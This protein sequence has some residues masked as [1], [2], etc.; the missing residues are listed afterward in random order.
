MT[1]SANT[2]VAGDFVFN[3]FMTLSVKTV[4]ACHVTLSVNSVEASVTYISKLVH[5]AL[6]PGCYVQ[7]YS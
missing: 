6:L 2:I 1:L 7:L 5:F 4:K 3:T